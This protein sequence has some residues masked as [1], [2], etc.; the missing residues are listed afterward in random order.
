MN[1]QHLCDENTGVC[2]FYSLHAEGKR[3][4]SAL[5]EQLALCCLLWIDWCCAYSTKKQLH[6]KS[7]PGKK[8][9][10]QYYNLEAVVQ[11]LVFTFLF[12]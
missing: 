6:L 11:L 1:V 2:N 3:V 8:K 10:I 5:R 7:C 12:L 9:S 4:T